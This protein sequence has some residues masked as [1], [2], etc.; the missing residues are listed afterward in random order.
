MRR[1]RDRRRA[2]CQQG[3]TLL[4]L[5][6]VIG[7][8]ALAV[9]IVAPSLNRARL[10]LTVRSAAYELAAGLRAARAAA[11]S[12]NRVEIVTLDLSRRGYWAEGVV[13]RRTFPANVAVELAVP[14]SERLGPAAGRVRFFPDGSASG[15]SVVLSDGRRA[16]SV[17]VDWLNGDVRIE[18]RP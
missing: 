18:L 2:A 3:F 12:G 11:Q 5:M 15:A 9:A 14:E 6:V 17:L 10:S 1:D 4:E 16:A 13:A 7:I 8:L